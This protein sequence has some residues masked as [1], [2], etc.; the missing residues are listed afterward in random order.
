MY[1]LSN[2]FQI[3]P[4]LSYFQIKALELA[5]ELELC[6]KPTLSKISKNMLVGVWQA[7]TTTCP[8]QATPLILTHRQWTD[9]SPVPQPS[10]KLN[11]SSSPS[12][13]ALP[14]ERVSI[15]CTAP[16]MRAIPRFFLFPVMSQICNNPQA[17]SSSVKTLQLKSFF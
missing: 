11:L 9:L 12:Q 16:V 3:Q 14:K 13:P 6:K 2:S 5:R 4:A 1:L 10:A 8:T 17:S 15:Q 7:P